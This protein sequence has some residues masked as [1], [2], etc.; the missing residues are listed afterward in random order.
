MALGPANM[1]MLALQ[2]E[3]SLEWVGRAAAIIAES[4]ASYDTSHPR[5][6]PRVPLDQLGEA[7]AIDDARC[8][9]ELVAQLFDAQPR[10]LIDYRA[11]LV[12]DRKP[13]KPINQ[14]LL[15]IRNLMMASAVERRIADGMV[16]KAAIGEVADKYG[17]GERTVAGALAE[18]RRARA[19]RDAGN[20]EN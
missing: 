9:L 11:D 19:S 17:I 16:R 8:F 15:A 12:L 20:S 7:V 10:T 2:G 14:D 5:E 13:G 4:L 3:V 1:A 18:L 6:L